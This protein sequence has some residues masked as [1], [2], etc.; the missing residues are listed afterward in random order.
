MKMVADVGSQFE[1]ALVDVL[2]VVDE[3]DLDGP[4]FVVDIE[5]GPVLPCPDAPEPLSCQRT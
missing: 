4:G 5:D 3:E 1:Q 2:P